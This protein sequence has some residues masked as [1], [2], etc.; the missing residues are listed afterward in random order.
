[1]VVCK[2]DS[3]IC[4]TEDTTARDERREVRCVRKQASKISATFGFYGTREP[5]LPQKDI[6]GVLICRLRMAGIF[7]TQRT[8]SRWFCQ[9]F[10]KGEEIL[11]TKEQKQSAVGCL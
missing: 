2:R 5:F 9:S 1:M 4:D 8:N 7:S 10:S 11:P 6:L 3:F